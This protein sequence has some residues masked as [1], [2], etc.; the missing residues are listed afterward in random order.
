MQGFG[1]SADNILNLLYSGSEDNAK[2]AATIAEGL[3]IPIKKLIKAIGWDELGFSNSKD[4]YQKT[5]CSLQY[6]RLQST[7]LLA[8]AAVI[9]KI[10]LN[11]SQVDNFVQ[12]ENLQR[13]Y[14][15][16]LSNVDCANF[17]PKPINSLIYLT[18]NNLKVDLAKKIAFVAGLSNLKEL[19]FG[20]NGL[21]NADF[22]SDLERLEFLVL[23]NNELK[24]LKVLAKLNQLTHLNVSGN[25]LKEIHLDNLVNLKKLYI[26]G[27][28]LGELDISTTY[29]SALCA[30]ACELKNIDL[31]AQNG[32]DWVELANNK[33][34]KFELK[35]KPNLSKLNLGGNMIKELYLSNL[36]NLRDLN[37]I[38]N[39]I[40]VISLENLPNLTQLRLLPELEN[41]P[42]HKEIK[43]QLDKRVKITF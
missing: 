9:Q 27:N 30:S 42:I 23:N 37:I 25:K 33:L 6:S 28:K 41:T 14:L 4:F 34:R 7:E 22:L 17:S 15:L 1:N 19:T 3:H 24:E 32:L 2:L 29:L 5:V 20:N 39:P 40:E 18:A 38:Q 43:K 36:P 8:K 13:L 35:N 11:N 16:D 12:L 21:N 31:N 26:D 10:Y